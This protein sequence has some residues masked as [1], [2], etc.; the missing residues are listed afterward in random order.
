MRE[1]C[2]TLQDK[3]CEINNIYSLS[4]FVYSSIL[5]KP[6]E[7]SV[8][9]VT[10][11]LQSWPFSFSEA[12]TYPSSIGVQQVQKITTSH[13]GWQN[14]LQFY[15]CIHSPCSWTPGKRS[16]LVYVCGCSNSNWKTHADFDAW[17][18]HYKTL[19]YNAAVSDSSSFL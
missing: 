18:A 13:F 12:L 5:T 19:G 4:H 2:E 9:W 7:Y 14:L 10:M 8:L 17:N 15:Y 16:Y 3:N 11:A 6:S 1:K